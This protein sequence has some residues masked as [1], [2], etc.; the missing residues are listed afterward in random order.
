M[1]LTLE[2]VEQTASKALLQ[3][4]ELEEVVLDLLNIHLIQAVQERLTLEVVEE[5]E[6][7][8]VLLHTQEATVVLASLF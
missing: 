3:L 1:L 7:L 5:L 6:D 2:A 4:V 8:M